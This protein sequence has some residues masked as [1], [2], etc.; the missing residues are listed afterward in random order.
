MVKSQSNVAEVGCLF[1]ISSASMI[2][3]ARRSGVSICN[4]LR[5]CDHRRVDLQATRVCLLYVTGGRRRSTATIA[6]I[7][8]RRRCTATIATIRNRLVVRF[9]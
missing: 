7:E 9:R 5:V 4:Q 1:A 3:A 2:T 8:G 6:T